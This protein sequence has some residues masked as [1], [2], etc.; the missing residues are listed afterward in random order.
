MTGPKVELNPPVPHPSK[1]LPKGPSRIRLVIAVGT[2]WESR[3]RVSPPFSIQG[4]S[5]AKKKIF[6]LRATNERLLMRLRLKTRVEGATR[7][8]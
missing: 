7:Q 6:T 1:T 5:K 3:L 4:V 8:M 2:D